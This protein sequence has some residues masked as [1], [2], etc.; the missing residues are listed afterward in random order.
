MFIK[1]RN[2]AFHTTPIIT[3]MYNIIVTQYSLIV[4]A[5]P[6]IQLSDSYDDFSSVRFSLLGMDMPDHG[7]SA[8]APTIAAPAALGYC[9]TV[10]MP[11]LIGMMPEMKDFEEDETDVEEGLDLSNASVG[12]PLRVKSPGVSS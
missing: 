8:H 9:P 5:E 1:T 4:A 7:Q 3:T 2:V 6:K 11:T 12:V 10:S